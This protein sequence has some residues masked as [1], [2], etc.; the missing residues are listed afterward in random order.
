MWFW[1]II[2]IVVI[3]LIAGASRNN[4]IVQYIADAGTFRKYVRYIGNSLGMQT[5]PE[6]YEI[7]DKVVRYHHIQWEEVVSLAAQA[8]SAGMFKRAALKRQWENADTQLDRDIIKHFPASIISKWE[9][10]SSQQRT[11]LSEIFWEKEKKL[12]GV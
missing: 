6:L 2:A 12:M 10:M 7:E 5:G 9:S 3:L 4:Q 1:I 11:R 8:Q